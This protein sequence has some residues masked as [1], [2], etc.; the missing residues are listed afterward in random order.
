MLVIKSTV[1]K[2][3]IENI[4]VERMNPTCVSQPRVKSVKIHNDK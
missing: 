4:L 2:R 1:L 3:L